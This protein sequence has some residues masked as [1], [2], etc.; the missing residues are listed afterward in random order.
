MSIMKKI[1]S[2]RVL[3]YASVGISKIGRNTDNSLFL[4]TLVDSAR[5]DMR[6]SRVLQIGRPKRGRSLTIQRESLRFHLFHSLSTKCE[7]VLDFGR[8]LLQIKLFN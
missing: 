6:E 1:G 8:L 3:I 7:L 5:P 2:F 4:V